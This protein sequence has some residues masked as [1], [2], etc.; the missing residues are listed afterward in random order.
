MFFIFI[1]QKK[2]VN[3]SASNLQFVKID[4][5]YYRPGCGQIS[6]NSIASKSFELWGEFEKQ[7]RRRTVFHEITHALAFSPNFFQFFIDDKGETKKRELTINT[8]KI[9][10]TNMSIP[11]LTSDSFKKI[12]ADYF[13]CPT[14]RGFPLAQKDSAHYSQQIIANQS[15]RPVADNYVDRI[16]PIAANIY[17]ETGW[18]IV[19]IEK[20]ENTLWGKNKGCDFLDFKCKDK[21]GKIFD[22]YCD[23]A[24]KKNLIGCDYY[25]QNISR[26][27][28]SKVLKDVTCP[29]MLPSAKSCRIP[30]PEPKAS[31]IGEVVGRNSKCVEINHEK[32]KKRLAACYESKCDK[33]KKTITFKVGETEVLFE[34]DE[35]FNAK[36]AEKKA[37]FVAKGRTFT[38]PLIAPSFERFCFN[39]D[40]IQIEKGF[41]REDDDNN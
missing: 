28:K 41:R 35:K 25:Y 29:Y 27:F 9:P 40:N 32:T 13:N 24:D 12:A 6:I 30:L 5:A 3:A 23:L 39:F 2:R 19:T 11:H 21:N 1:G 37:E 16:S 15:M 26:C 14:A 34:Y 22:E 36:V 8:Y 38:L 4:E 10:G 17:K 33:E 31:K 18:Y 7:E 20:Y